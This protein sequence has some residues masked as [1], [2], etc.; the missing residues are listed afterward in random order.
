[1]AK[2]SRAN[3]ISS[4]KAEEDRWR[5]ESDLRTM[6]DAEEIEKDPKRLAAVQKLAKEKMM[7]MAG[8]A[9]EGADD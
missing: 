1:M 9:T 6:L 4:P 7:T 3:V 5:A 2:S 8:I